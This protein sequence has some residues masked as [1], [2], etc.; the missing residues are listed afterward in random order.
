MT[1]IATVVSLNNSAWSIMPVD[2]QRQGACEAN[3]ICVEIQTQ[4][5]IAHHDIAPL[6][7]QF[8]YNDTR[9]IMHTFPADSGSTDAAAFSS[10]ITHGIANESLFIY[11]GGNEAVVPPSSVYDQAATQKALSYTS[12]SVYDNYM[13]MI[14]NVATQIEHGKGVLISV[15]DM[16]LDDGY[17]I[18]G[19]HKVFVTGVDYAN[20]KVEFQN[21]WGATWGPQGNG[22]GHINFQDFKNFGATGVQAM[23]VCNGFAGID[24]TWTANKMLAAAD[25]IVIGRSSEHSGNVYYDNLLTAGGVNN[26]ALLDGFIASGEGQALYGGKTNTQFV[27]ALY[28]HL[29]GRAADAGAIPFYANQLDNGQSRGA[30]A[31]QLLKYWLGHSGTSD[32][33]FAVNCQTVSSNAAIT[34]QADDNHHGALVASL[35]GITSDAN[36]VESGKMALWHALA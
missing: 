33:D 29:C 35:V 6:S 23:D 17:T 3:A 32:G 24:L 4:M 7:R 22:H 20:Q 27:Q 28:P 21:S 36:T 8:L 26:A 16:R 14:G 25:Y 11:G 9:I 13:I 30:L 18:W 15:Q 31:D 34:Y 1:T 19:G 2:Q 5:K 10:S 12:L